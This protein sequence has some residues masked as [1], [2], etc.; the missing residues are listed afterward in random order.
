MTAYTLPAPDAPAEEWGRLAVSIPGWLW[1]P[2]M[3]IPE[4]DCNAA[5]MI[6]GPGGATACA[7]PSPASRPSCATT[8]RP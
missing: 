5:A 6:W 4:N 8:L 7:P 3:S 1:M 2:G